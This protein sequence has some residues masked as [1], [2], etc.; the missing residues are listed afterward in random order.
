MAFIEVEEV[1]YSYPNGVQ[2]VDNVSF[3][4]D[5][6][7]SVAIIGQN[8][9][10]KTT[11]VKLLNGLL[12]P[13]RGSIRVGKTDTASLTAAQTARHVGYVFQNPDDQ[14]FNSTVYNEVEYALKRRKI[15]P[16]ESKRR[17]IEVAELCGLS[18][19]LETN[20]YDLPLSIRKFV[21]IAS[22]LA[23][24]PEV[25]ILDEPTAGQDLSGLKRISEI[26]RHLES[27]QKIVITITHDMEFVSE[28][29]KRVI[30]MANRR[31]V[32]E[33]TAAEIFQNP[34]AMREARLAQPVFHALIDKIDLDV[35]IVTLTELVE[36]LNERR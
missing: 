34:E 31:I 20:P 33:G 4:V 17:I 12:K 3:T 15:S 28:N 5:K 14:I 23:L 11:T 1:S 13:T 8:G 24:D 32:T 6:G 29:F 26:I 35:P 16:E 18:D 7:E 25:V 36:Y 21:T 10:G 9:A 2:A 19:H 27:Q 30:V 22:V